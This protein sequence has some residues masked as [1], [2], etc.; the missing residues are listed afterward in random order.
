M[1]LAIP[2]TP[3]GAVTG[4]LI[5][6]ARPPRRR[7]IKAAR[8][9]SALPRPSAAASQQIIPM[10]IFYTNYFKYFHA[11]AA[12]ATA[13]KANRRREPGKVLSVCRCQ[14]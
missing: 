1:N 14:K 7:S 12:A 3:N 2:P 6:S 13:G 8:N 9:F 4:Q 11:A 5:D 10:Q